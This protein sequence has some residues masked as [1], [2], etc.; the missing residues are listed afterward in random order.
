MRWQRGWLGQHRGGGGDDPDERGPPV[1]ERE[2]TRRQGKI[3]KPK[4]KTYS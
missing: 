1:G 2:E 4:G 3:H